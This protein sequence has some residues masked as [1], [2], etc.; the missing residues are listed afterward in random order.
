MS[1]QFLNISIYFD[2]QKDIVAV[3]SIA[4]DVSGLGSARSV[5]S[6][7][8]F[9][10]GRAGCISPGEDIPGIEELVYN[11]RLVRAYECHSPFFGLTA[12]AML[13][14]QS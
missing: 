8:P 12:R 13:A 5:R 11:G 1:Q 10:E 6:I 3:M 7:W 14:A 9:W 2:F 4:H